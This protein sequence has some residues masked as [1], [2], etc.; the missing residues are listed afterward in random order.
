MVQLS[1]SLCLFLS[2]DW[3]LSFCDSKPS[4]EVEWRKGRLVGGSPAK[5]DLLSEG[6]SE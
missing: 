3:P 5:S 2:E 6:D 1:S 4:F